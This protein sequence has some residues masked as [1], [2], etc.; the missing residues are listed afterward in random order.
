MNLMA[1][2]AHWRDRLS[3]AVIVKA[4]PDNDQFV[5]RCP[6]DQTV[7]IVDAPRPIAGQIAAQ[8]F[9]LSDASERVARRRS[10]QGINALQRFFVLLVPVQI[11]IPGVW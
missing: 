6:I 5:I 11:S 7:R 2:L 3:L 4:A 9:R 1:H 8:R 10:D